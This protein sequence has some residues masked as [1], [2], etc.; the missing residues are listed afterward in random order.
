MTMNQVLNI[1]QYSL[2]KSEELFS[3]TAKEKI[4]SKLVLLHAYLKLQL[5]HS[6]LQYVT[7]YFLLSAI[8]LQTPPFQSCLCP[9]YFSKN[10]GMVI[11]FPVSQTRPHLF[12]LP[13]NFLVVIT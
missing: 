5:N 13:T 2:Q 8:F 6:S 1:E 3:T 11:K 10:M 12:L 7:L 9:C 4:F